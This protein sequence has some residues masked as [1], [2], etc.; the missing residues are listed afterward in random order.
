MK[1]H[2]FTLAI[3]LLAGTFSA[4][5]AQLLYSDSF[6][7]PGKW[8]VNSSEGVVVSSQGDKGYTGNGLR[9]DINFTLG[10]GY[11]GVFDLVS[12][13]LPENYQ[14]TFYVKAKDLPANNFEF[15][16]I[17]PSGDNVWWVNRK[18]YEFPSEWT[19][20]TVRKRNLAFA[21]GP[22]GGGEIKKMGRL[23]LIV[24]SING[25]K[26]SVWIDE[27]RIEKL[28]PPAVTTAQPVVTIS[29]VNDP[30]ASASLFDGNGNTFYK[31][32]A[33]Q[34]EIELLVDFTVQR[35]FGGFVLDWDARYFPTS[36]SVEASN[37][38]KNWT[39]I[40]NNKGKAGKTYIIAAE[41]QYRYLKF[42]IH[43][44]NGQETR[45]NDITL[46]DLSFADN[47]NNLYYAIAAD[48]PKGWFPRYTLKQQSYFTVTGVSG[49]V[50]EGLLNE[51][52]ML[53]TDKQQFSV[54]PFLNLNGKLITWND[55]KIG[56]SLAENYIP[57]P[58][59]RWISDDFT[60]DV[61]AF[62]GGEPGSSV[63]YSEYLVTNTGK[64]PLK[65][66]FYL[67]L[68][69]F[70][71]NPPW[72]DLNFYG[73]TARINSIE[74]KDGF[75]KVNG[76]TAVIPLGITGK[77][78]ALTFDD[79]DISGHMAANTLPAS[80]LVSDPKGL[81]SGAYAFD[82]DL[83]PGEMARFTFAIPQYTATAPEPVLRESAK[84]DLFSEANAKAFNFWEKKL[85]HIDWSVPKELQTVFNSVKSN[86]G[87]ILINRD[88]VGIQPGSRSYERSWIRDGALTSAALL[89][90][91]LKQ[92]MKEFA[93]WYSKY[94][95]PNGK[96]PCVVDKRGPDP[97]PE[98]DA[99]GEFI[100]LIYQYY[101]YTGDKEFVKNL[102]PKVS[103]AVDFIRE[104]I[105]QRS[106][107]HFRDNLNDSIRSLYGLVPESISHEGY[108]DKPMHSYW[109]N[110]FTLLGLKDAVTMAKLL[111]YDEIAKSWAGTRD[112]FYTNLYN[113][114]RLSI[115]RT[116]IDY[117]P[118]CAEKG[119]FDATS[120]TIAVYPGGE[121]NNLP[122]PEL[123]NT[124]KRYINYV[125]DRV[126][127][128]MK[129]NEYTPYEMRTIGTFNF[130]GQ[131]DIAWELIQYFMADQRPQGWNHWAEVVTRDYRFARFLGDMP[132]TWCG[133]DFINAIRAMVIHER[134]SDNSILIAPGFP[135]AWYEFEEGFSFRNLPTYYG[136]LNYEIK[137]KGQ[138]ANIYISGDVNIPEGGIRYVVPKKF[139]KER[140]ELDDK[141]VEPNAQGEIL[142]KSLPAKVEL[143]YWK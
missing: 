135:D 115:K 121:I 16:V 119:D 107:P 76:K 52:G 27:L 141:W 102:F 78:G 28:D 8:K 106:T 37:D 77:F 129:W 90:M 41:S 10:S 50:K 130:N 71:V 136:E 114:I 66:K 68:R 14:M 11:G 26:G 133:S 12:L 21:W 95:Y 47:Y 118:G 110:F 18:G 103:S 44:G 6:E 19:K 116:G 105:S 36:F 131:T 64:A 86:V 72:Q 33:G 5:N 24:A 113:S 84:F 2:I 75:A 74:Y 139:R 56:H 20:I 62:A 4:S 132:H 137:K 96:V 104:M 87:Y 43:N 93:E 79:G 55:V 127:G 15:K 125:R 13:D 88:V 1:T 99:N 57:I 29:P 128:K 82:L 31:S 53:E 91:G 67:A 51:D 42:K 112:T 59:V 48:H 32:G 97:V 94:L 22:Q 140:V 98:N 60:M 45:L 35:E 143:I 40:S 101:R 138:E 122:Q 92:E 111:G 30:A 109:D 25:G 123:N 73:G 34:K 63:L 85:S 3:F 49:D 108:S 46:K 83:K 120:T 38:L 9:F 54:E 65:G 39:P 70:Q 134:E 142:I 17:D 80:Q 58:S 117:I 100:Y 23:E 124:F 126:Q 7:N 69:P 61:T 89:K 81:A